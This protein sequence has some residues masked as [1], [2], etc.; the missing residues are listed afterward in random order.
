MSV[1]G[2]GIDIVEVGRIERLIGK[3]DKAFTARVFTES[4]LESTQENASTVQS[5]A[6]RFAVKEAIVKAFGEGFEDGVPWTDMEISNEVSG[7]P[8]V[9]LLGY[10]RELQQE[11][12]VD[13]VLVSLSHTS[14]HALA[15]ALL[16]R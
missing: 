6:A 7:R 10:M 3:W 14:K 15:S 4:E 1:I 2:I 13:R 9:K 16:L 8:V 5:L 12:Q 11:R